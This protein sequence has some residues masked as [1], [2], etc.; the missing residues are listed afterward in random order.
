MIEN[1][2]TMYS[3]YRNEAWY[4]RM[5]KRKTAPEAYRFITENLKAPT[6]IHEKQNAYAAYQ[7]LY[8]HPFASPEE[9]R[10]NEDK[11]EIERLRE[12]LAAAKAGKEN[13]GNTG[14]DLL[15]A[16]QF[17]EKWIAE[18]GGADVPLPRGRAW[19]KYKKENGIVE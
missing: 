15:T 12:E 1:N 18:N 8:G 14:G 11:K 2:Q 19:A 7:Q 6:F 3:G 5:L 10:A 16:E 17:K 9:I 13:Q 4:L